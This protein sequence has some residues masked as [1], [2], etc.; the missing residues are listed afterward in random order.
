MTNFIRTANWLKACG[1]EQGNTGHITT[2]LGC[3]IEEFTELL[4]RIKKHDGEAYMLITD[5][6]VNLEKV[7]E[8]FK[9]GYA[10]AY[11]LHQDRTE[12]L[13]AFC[14]I[15]VTVNGLAYLLAMDKEKADVLVLDSNDAKLVDGKPI[16][17]PGGKIG[18]PEGWPAPDL[19]G[20][21]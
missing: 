5:A 12:V 11:F 1:K 9:H 6:I 14:D 16:I 8:A 17:L 18:K 15:E 2:Q 7:A 20:C 21:V 10:D 13:D 19:L 3:V 4:S